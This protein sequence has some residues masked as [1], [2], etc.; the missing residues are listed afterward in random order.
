M[1]ASSQEFRSSFGSF[2]RSL[3]A[4]QV[5]EDQIAAEAE[6]QMRRA[7]VAGIALSHVDTHKH[8]HLFPAVLRAV[9]QA[10][11]SC[12]VRAIR[13]PFAP[14]KPLGFAHLL[15]RPRLWRRYTEVA[16]LRGWSESFRRAV[17]AAGMV[18]TDGTFGILST[19]ALDLKL[20]RAIIGCIP[21]GTWEFCCHPGHNDDD[22]AKTRTRLRASREQ[23]LA[24]ITSPEARDIMARNGIELISYWDL[25][26]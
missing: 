23:E 4:R 25:D 11:R 3:L 21:P 14:V 16:V 19:G 8:L 12:G 9:L 24:V 20:F 26:S 10:A 6:E 18:T 5:Q 1:A 22:L 2:A 13:N 15:R 7:Q 17:R